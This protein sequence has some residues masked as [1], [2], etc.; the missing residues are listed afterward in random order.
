MGIQSCKKKNFK[1]NSLKFNSLLSWGF[2]YEKNF[3]GALKLTITFDCFQRNNIHHSHVNWH[4]FMKRQ[5]IFME[6]S[7][8]FLFFWRSQNLLWWKKN[9]LIISSSNTK[10]FKWIFRQYSIFAI[11]KNIRWEKKRTN[12]FLLLKFQ[13][14]FPRRQIISSFT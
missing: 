13:K 10:S 1:E 8:I 4:F 12:F 5:E 6:L 14:N 7:L 11:H 3:Y 2:F 9:S